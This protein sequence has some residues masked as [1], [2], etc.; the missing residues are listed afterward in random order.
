MQVNTTKAS[1]SEVGKIFLSTTSVT[2]LVKLSSVE[3]MDVGNV[4]QGSEPETISLGAFR[5][6]EKPLN[7]STL[8]ANGYVDGT[9]A[10][11]YKNGTESIFQDVTYSCKGFD[12]YAYSNYKV[13]NRYK[14]YINLSSIKVSMSLNN[15]GSNNNGDANITAIYVKNKD[16][17]AIQS[18]TSLTK[19]IDTTNDKVYWNPTSTAHVIPTDIATME[20]VYISWKVQSWDNTDIDNDGG[21]F[22][23]RHATTYIS[24]STSHYTTT[25]NESLSASKSG[26]CSWPPT[27]ALSIYQNDY[28]GPGSAENYEGSPSEIEFFGTKMTV[29]GSGDVPF[30]VS[31][32]KFESK[33]P[34]TLPS[35][36]QWYIAFKDG[37]TTT[38][39]ATTTSKY[40]AP[41]LG[42]IDLTTIA[43]ELLGG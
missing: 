16:K 4:G 8:E 15:G 17:V 36:Y 20:K 22:N 43:V 1:L 30:G 12:Q 7:T 42:N 39:A 37:T 24:T 41:A 31:S 25:S 14:D 10:L 13:Y 26:S 35:G 32:F 5:G 21:A 23:L 3:R 11:T 27:F 40:E 28:F 38:Y 6:K 34:E 9:S 2:Q 18:L 29:W 33:N 19:T